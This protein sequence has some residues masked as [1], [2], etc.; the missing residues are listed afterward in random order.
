M[1]NNSPETLQKVSADLVSNIFAEFNGNA[2]PVITQPTKEEAVVPKA[3]EDTELP[4][5]TPEPKAP[6]V[7]VKLETDHAKKLKGLIEDGFLEN[8]AINYEGE[9]L[10]LDEIQD[11]SKEGYDEILK[12]WKEEKEKQ[13]KEKY[14][15][16]DGISERARKLLEIDRAG[17]D[18]SEII[19]E[20]VTAISQLE[21]LRD[22][23]SEE[24]VQINIVGND[25][26]NRGI[27]QKVAEAQIRALI[28][29]GD[30]E[31]QATEI[32]NGHLRIHNDAIETKR[33]A[34]LD[35][36]EKKKQGIKDLK[37]DLS[38]TYKEWKVPETIAKQ[39]LDNATKMDEYDISNT[40]KLYFEAQ[41]DPQ[42]FAEINYF[43][44]NPEEFKKF[45]SSKKVL[46]SKLEG[47]FKPLLSIRIDQT[48]KAKLS[49]DSL[50]DFAQKIMNDNNK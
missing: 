37:K 25:L 33:V 30:L 20:N 50:E 35:K 3:T 10:Y 22:N 45:I 29:E 17:G 23:I 14:V 16:V 2:E 19:R 8:F 7:P 13:K 15:S 36:V 49:Q 43:L 18:I 11:L 40:D 48:K 28:D 42:R 32:L 21:G 44:N 4:T 38:S 1:E 27:S 31:T 24:K 6:E 5:P 47:R 46:E 26:M 34:E 41:K 12:G 9:D 39:L